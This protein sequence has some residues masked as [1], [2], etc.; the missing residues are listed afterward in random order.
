M[1]G[2]AAL[3]TERN[4]YNLSSSWVGSWPLGN[5]SYGKVCLFLKQDKNSKIVDRLAIKETRPKPDERARHEWENPL[6]WYED[7]KG[8]RMPTEVYAMEKLR[9]RGPP[10][11]Y[12]VSLRNWRIQSHPV[13]HCCLRLYMEPCLAG[14]L[15]D[16]LSYNQGLL[17]E[18]FLW[19]CFEALANVG[20]LAQYG[21]LD[22]RRRRGHKTMLHR[23]LKTPNIFCGAASTSKFRGY[24]TP[25]LGDWGL[26]VVMDDNETRPVHSFIGAGTPGHRPVESVIE[27]T[28]PGDTESTMPSSKVDVFG[29]DHL[30]WDPS[31]IDRDASLSKLRIEPQLSEKALEFYSTALTDLVGACTRYHPDQRPTFQEL[32]KRVLKAGSHQN[33]TQAARHAAADDEMWSGIS[34]R[35]KLDFAVVGARLDQDIIRS[36]TAVD[37]Y[38]H[39]MKRFPDPPKADGDRKRP[40]GG[41]TGAELDPSLIESDGPP[42]QKKRRV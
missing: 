4:L 42:Q 29:E 20:L 38:P 14:D 41:P 35:H 31:I 39:G 34:I 11:E 37:H 3:E 25:K 27:S 12:V 21:R 10:S 24:P 26:T 18:P 30:A 2:Q 32:L 40:P 15:F 7:S 22:G 16:I 28:F 1:D 33:E 36:H 23:D 19:Y 5:G 6:V 8:R 13:E 17:P 9:G